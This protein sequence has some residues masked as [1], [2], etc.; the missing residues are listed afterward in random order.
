V[1]LEVAEHLPPGVA[2][3]FVDALV[4][5]GSVVLFSAAIPF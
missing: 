2:Q 3:T 4:R 5:H 1:S